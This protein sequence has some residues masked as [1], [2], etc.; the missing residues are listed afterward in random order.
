VRY[1]TNTQCI[2]DNIY[3]IEVPLP[4]NPLKSI[5]SY[6]IKGQRNLVIDTGMNRIECEQAIKEA[7]VELD[8][9][10]ENTDFF[11]THMHAD[12]SGLIGKLATSSSTVYFTEEDAPYILG[13]NWDEFWYQEALYAKKFGFP[14]DSLT[15]AI[16]KHPGYKYAFRGTLNAKVQIVQ[17]KQVLNYGN[18]NLSCIKT[19]GHT[20]GI[21]CLYEPYKKLFFSSDHV[22]NDITPNISAAYENE[23]PLK[24]YLESL[25]KVYKLNV[26]LVLPGHRKLFTNL[27]KRIDE[28]KKHHRERLNEILGL[29]DTKTP[30]D[31][32]Y[33]ASKMHW[34]I[35]YKN[36]ED[37]PISQKWFAHSEAI[38]HLL[39][40]V[41]INKAKMFMVNDTYCFI[42][43]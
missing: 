20:K 38:A 33:I 4:Q 11:I 12:H 40:L 10:L 6:V 2:I 8:I 19:P 18:Y 37:F 5:N 26:E 30:L 3:K 35:K 17:D 39:Y 42:K 29:L 24:Q 32:Y 27:Q 23:N 43:A 28:L 21:V 1:K 14:I 7:F 36:W 9:N 16:K 34:D 25:D 13:T 22:L 41:E 15:N 31:A